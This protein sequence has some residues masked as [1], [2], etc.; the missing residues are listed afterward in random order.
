MPQES[1]EPRK[2][3]HAAE[4]G[5]ERRGWAPRVCPPGPFPADRPRPSSSAPT[6]QSMAS[7]SSHSRPYQSRAPRHLGSL[8]KVWG[9]ERRKARAASEVPKH[10]L[11]KRLLAWGGRGKAAPQAWLGAQCG[12][13]LSGGYHSRG[14]DDESGHRRPRPRHRRPQSRSAPACA[15]PPPAG[16]PGQARGSGAGRRWACHLCRPCGLPRVQSALTCPL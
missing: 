4:M 13:G 6:E 7:E 14:G 5:G 10:S 16:D 15:W 1:G 2:A 8:F 11:M 12:L 9:G 3:T